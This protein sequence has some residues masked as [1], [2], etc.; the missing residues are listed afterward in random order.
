[1]NAVKNR[2]PQ[3]L[4]LGFAALAFAAMFWSACGGD[5]N[6]QRREVPEFSID[7]VTSF[8]FELS[9]PPND[10]QEEVQT[11]G[12]TLRNTG[13]TTLNVTRLELLNA[14]ER[15]VSWS[16]TE[17][18][19][20]MDSECEGEGE[21]ICLNNQNC[22][23][24]GLPETPFEIREGGGVPIDFLLR[25][26]STELV[27]PEAPPE[28]D[29]GFADLYCG[30]LIIETNADN[31]SGVVENG[32]ARIVFLRPNLSGEIAI[33]P[34]FIEFEEVQPA[35]TSSREF[36]VQNVGTQPLTIEQIAVSDRGAFFSVSGG[37]ELPVVLES[38]QNETWTLNL[39]VPS[40]AT[41]DEYTGFTDL[42]V[43]SS[44]T[45]PS[46]GIVPVSVSAEASAAPDIEFSQEVLKFDGSSTQTLTIENTGSATLIVNRLN[47][48][49]EAARPFYSFEID[50]TD[51]TD[52]FPQQNVPRGESIE[53]TINFDRP[54][55]NADSSVSA[56][57]VGHN[58]RAKNQRSELLLLGDAGDVP[59]ARIH[60]QGFTF[61][62]EAGN[63]S[64][65]TYVVRN[66]GTASLEVTS[67]MM[68]FN[69]GNDAEFTISG[70]PMT[71]PPGGFE[72]GTV[73]FDGAN[74][75]PDVGNAIFATNDDVGE[76]RLGIKDVTSSSDAVIPVVRRDF[77]NDARVNTT[78]QFSAAD[79][80][81]AS[82]ASNAIWTLIERPAGSEV[83]FFNVGETMSF[84]PDTVGT[85]R[86]SLIVS[87]SQREAEV[88][89]DVEVV[90]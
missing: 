60:P 58:V 53:V 44:A 40:D 76:L 75:T 28:I 77:A 83:F 74:A 37:S 36:S 1:M 80:E 21:Q 17:Q 43:I 79:S 9:L 3:S 67:V 11:P 72:T 38:Q 15:L 24:L 70:V 52:Q 47:V 82:S 16:S 65:R 54:G 59:V 50:G 39:E 34:T 62:A 41:E 49:N 46:A 78:L 57:T 64:T 8:Q 31:Q 51:A 35:S 23:K 2:F 55:G 61:F 32:N 33:T 10:D 5:S 69:Q 20:S 18:S 13:L 56:L 66:I 6:V 7:G 71:I 87:Q 48:Q 25:R 68:E 30:E 45:N 90:E 84:V 89:H 86:F 22:V 42:E 27:C 81:P 26:G 29:Q 4:L 19:C 85:Y 14:P 12:M 88:V 73:S 63:S